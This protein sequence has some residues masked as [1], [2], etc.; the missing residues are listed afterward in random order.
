MRTTTIG[1]GRPVLLLHG[2]AMTP[3]VYEA[4]AALLAERARVSVVMPW[5]FALAKRWS[6]ERALD[7]LSA[8]VEEL[9]A[10]TM[11]IIGHSFSGGIELGLAGRYPK[12]FAELV[13]ADTL[14]LSR[15]W[16]L[17]G[18]FFRHPVGIVKMATVP[19]VAAFAWSVS[20]HPDQLARAGWWGFVR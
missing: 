13:F 15:E 12:R 14:G 7:A 2:F 16:H 11:S 17:A 20:R 6:A 5:M 18:E 9:D 3:T 10:P 8:I 1:E 4:T 19:A